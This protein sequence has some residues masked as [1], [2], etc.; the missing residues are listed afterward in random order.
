MGDIF[1]KVLKFQIF[2]G[3]LEIPDIFFFWGGGRMVDV[4]PKPTYGEILRVSPLGA[5][6]FVQRFLVVFIDCS[7]C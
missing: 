6:S 4:G 1:W 5:K 7:S 2:F 3:V